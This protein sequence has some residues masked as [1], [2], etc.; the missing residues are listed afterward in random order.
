MNSIIKEW[1]LWM[2]SLDCKAMKKLLRWYDF[3]S[4]PWRIA[5]HQD[6]YFRQI[7][8]HYK[9]RIISDIHTSIPKDFSSIFTYALLKYNESRIE[10]QN[11]YNLGIFL[12][13]KWSHFIGLKFIRKVCNGRKLSIYFSCC[14]WNLFLQQ[15]CLVFAIMK[16]SENKSHYRE[17][18]V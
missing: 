8:L 9:I 7:T 2:M 16:S 1:I 17:S 10:Y 4:I 11:V 5:F 3:I 14:F 18:V 15:N 13:N 6:V 12:L